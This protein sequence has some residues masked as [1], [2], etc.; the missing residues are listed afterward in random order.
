MNNEANRT[1]NTTNNIILS[2]IGSAGLA[3]Q[4]E[5]AENARLENGGPN[6][7]HGSKMQD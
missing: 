7:M 5:G 3:L 6:S 1:V 4:G 2:A